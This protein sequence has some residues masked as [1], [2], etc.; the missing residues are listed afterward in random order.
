MLIKPQLPP[1]PTIQSGQQWSTIWI[2]FGQLVDYLRSL[3]LY[4][5]NYLGQ[6][7]SS[8]DNQ[9]QQGLAADLPPFGNP[10]RLYWTTDTAH[11]YIDTGT[12]WQMIV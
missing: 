9:I 11:L 6:V 3:V 7:Q 8:V 12:A 1:P 5:Q 4:L 10:N 2:R